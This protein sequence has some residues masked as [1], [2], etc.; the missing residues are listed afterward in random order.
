MRTRA[1]IA[2]EF[3]GVEELEDYMKDLQAYRWLKTVS[4]SQ[5]HL[6]LKFYEDITEDYSKKI[7]SFI[8]EIKYKRFE[9]RFKGMDC[10]PGRGKC[11]VFVLTSDSDRVKEIWKDISKRLG[12]D[13]EE[14][15]MTPHLTLGRVKGMCSKQ[16]L[17][18]ILSKK[19]DIT[20][21]ADRISLIRSVL[22]PEGPRYDEICTT[23]L[24]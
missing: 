11:R 17:D 3:L 18:Q 23:Q 15:E 9:V 12:K 21:R 6:T 22:T 13:R 10:F 8:K 2:L 14:R 20:L 5:M 24:I 7:C 16:D 4:I 19:I 1:F